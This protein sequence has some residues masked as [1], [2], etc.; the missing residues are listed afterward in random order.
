LA[1]A[2]EIAV[3]G[4]FHIVP[5]SQIVRQGSRGL[6]LY[7]RKLLHRFQTVVSVSPA[8]Q[9][10]ARRIY[11]LTSI[12]EPNTI[13]LGPYQKLSAKRPKNR[14]I[15]IVFLGRLVERKGCEYLLKAIVRLRE[16]PKI[17]PFR[18]IIGGRGP[19][20]TS[21]KRFVRDHN[22]SD[23]VEFAGFIDETDKPKF[24][25]AAD[26]AVFPSTG[27]ES[28]G[29]VL[30]EAMAASPGVVLAGNNEGYASVMKPHTKQLF[31]PADSHSLAKKLAYYIQS[32][33]AR[34][35]AHHWQSKHVQKYSIDVIGPRLIDIYKQALR[36]C[37]DVR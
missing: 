26:L 31:V 32:K 8:A 20:E 23:L 37:R 18:V 4:T 35:T 2:P 15:T 25:A 21:L 5:K 24:L 33:S 7:E 6:G 19:L 1:A 12:I 13:N 34:Q 22:L 36:R 10:F 17:K 30:L 27:G 3:I 14:P 16:Q 28:F 29:I 9:T 11:G